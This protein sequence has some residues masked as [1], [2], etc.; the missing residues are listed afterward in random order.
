V[1]MADQLHSDEA[2]S[3][4]TPPA[5]NWALAILL[6]GIIGVP[7]VVFLGALSDHENWLGPVVFLIIA[8]ALPVAFRLVGR[9]CKT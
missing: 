2:Q 7:A 5:R 1:P 4:P 3:P 6:W 9:G 8:F